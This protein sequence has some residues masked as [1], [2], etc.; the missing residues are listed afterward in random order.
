MTNEEVLAHFGTWYR[1]ALNSG[2]SVNAPTNWK[3]LGYIP[4]LSQLK[5]EKATEGQLIY[6]EEDARLHNVDMQ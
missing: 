1:A 4:T 6:R 3:R 5:I 2:F